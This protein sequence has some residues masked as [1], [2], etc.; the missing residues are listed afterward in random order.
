ME[1]ERELDSTDQLEGSSVY[2]IGCHTA[3][4]RGGGGGGLGGGFKGVW[5]NWKNRKSG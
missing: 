3:L 1:R 4:E 5:L 2:Q